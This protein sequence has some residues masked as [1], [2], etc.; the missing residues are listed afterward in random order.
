[1]KTRMNWKL[2]SRLSV[3]TFALL[4]LIVIVVVQQQRS[5][6]QGENMST[7][8]DLGSAPAPDFHLTD[9][10]GQQVSLSQF[11]GKPVVLTFLYTHCPDVCPLTAEHLH[12]TLV[13]LGSD[14]NKVAIIA[15][16]T[17]PRRDDRDAVEAF[18]RAHNMQNSW[19]FL[20]G[21]EEE[22]APVWSAY[23]IYARQQQE[24]VAHSFAVYVID[25]QG[26][27]HSFLSED[28]TPDQLVSTLKPL[29]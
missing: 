21:K 19:H 7:G 13:K 17:D 26:H 15:I 2:A 22:L 4:V 16:S 8:T 5:V 23:S 20:M 28:F 25:K 14:A 6:A 29:L 27:E 18:S 10:N 12:S 24:K 3:I 11:R 1:M 9:Q